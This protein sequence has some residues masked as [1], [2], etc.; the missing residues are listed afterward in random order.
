MPDIRCSNCGSDNPDFFDVCQ[1]CQAPLKPDPLLHIGEEPT[2]KKTDELEE[3]LPDWLKEARQQGKND[4]AAEDVF[5]SQTKPRV[6]KEE[7]PDLLAGLMSQADSDEDEVPDWLTEIN[8]V[9][10]MTPLSAPSSTGNEESSDFFAQFNREEPQP[11][12]PAGEETSQEELPSLM[13]VEGEPSG[14]EDELTDWFSPKPVDDSGWMKDLEGFDSAVQEPPVE[15]EPEDLSWL[16]DLE[17]ASKGTGELPDLPKDEGFEP[18]PSSASDEDL[19]WLKT[20]G[21]STSV[22]ETPAEE[23]PASSDNDLDWLNN[24]GGVPT[25]SAE[26]PA[27][28]EPAS[29]DEDLDWLN[30]LG[31]TPVSN[32][33]PTAKPP[34]SGD[35]MDWLNK[36]GETSPASFE[37]RE[38]PQ[39]SSAQDDDLSWL[40][41][42]GGRSEPEVGEPATPQPSSS[43]DELDWLN[44]LGGIA[45]SSEPGARAF[46]DTSELYGDKGE[47]PEEPKPFRTAPLHELLDGQPPIDTTPEWL[48]EAMQVPSMPAP[49]AV[50]MDW[51]SEHDKPGAVEKGHEETGVPAPGETSD[52]TQ[53]EPASPEPTFDFASTESSTPSEQDVDSLF[54]VEMPDWLSSE[55]RGEEAPSTESAPPMETADESLSPVE[56]PSWVQAMRPVDSAIDKSATGVVDQYVEREGPLAGFQGVIPAAPIGSSLRPKPLSLKLQVTDEQQA[57]ASLFEQIIAAETLPQP[58]KEEK[59]IS[60]Q[61]ILRW[62]L[63][64]L[65]LGMLSLV[66]GLGLQTIP[67]VPAGELSGLVATIP[68]A[69]HVLVVIDYEPSFAGELE[70]T[71]GPLL[72]Q[73]A[74]SR[75]STFTFVSMSPNGSAL[76]E[77]LLFNT[78]VSKA[79]GLGYQAGSGYF[80]LGFLPG[81]SAGVL[82]FIENPVEHFTRYEAV[83]LM[84][85]NAETGRV[86]IEQL[87]AADSE[88]SGK[89]L[90]LVSSAQSGPLLRPY[91]DSGQADILVNGLYDAARYEQMNVSRPGTARA[92]WDAF[93]TGL[94][95]AVL[96]IVLGSAW[97]VFMKVR[98]KRSEAEQE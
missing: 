93:G 13:G 18:I 34:P 65:I 70:A 23:Q 91:V 75:H 10:E 31:G 11:S 61:R 1:F 98:E 52:Q 19:D 7:P 44:K 63:S 40:D 39:P 85:D 12:E 2:K 43:Q 54:D 14:Q 87:E 51:F 48:K 21:G 26:E 90:L 92:Y 45:D 25:P 96:A 49:G 71:A 8:P 79:D 86:W 76:V 30:K 88:V 66:I 37:E 28:K 78:G 77:R 82:G 80:N 57:G 20:L 15:K 97:N 35:D 74:L 56:L 5:S 68:D 4:E 89:P 83:V 59:A 55:S 69:S 94:L 17:A 33:L 64:G 27:P 38:T 29:S 60:S 95:L 16:H 41:N 81:G 58:R 62:V 73:L 32:E 9:E 3:I 36:L 53:G 50:S 42:L 47:N 24:L 72:D 46:G 22:S 67:I 6:P 84:T